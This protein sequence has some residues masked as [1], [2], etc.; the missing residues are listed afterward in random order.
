M[1]PHRSFFENDPQVPLIRLAILHHLARL[2]GLLVHVKGMPV[3]SSRLR[4]AHPEPTESG[5]ST[6]SRSF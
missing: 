2:L 3:G 5:C 1:V 4:R 6:A